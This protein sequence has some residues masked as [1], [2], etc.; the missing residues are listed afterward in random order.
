ME[1]VKN[2]KGRYINKTYLW[3]ET[4]KLPTIHFKNWIATISKDVDNINPS[5]SVNWIKWIHNMVGFTHC[6]TC[7]RLHGC[8]FNALKMPEQPMHER[9]HCS[10]EPIPYSQ[11]LAEAKAESNYSKFDPYLFDPENFYKHKKNVLFEKWGYSIDDSKWLQAEIERQGR[12]KYIAGD[13][14]LGVLNHNGQ[15]ISIR[16]SIPRKDSGE[17]VSFITGWMLC[18]DGKIKLNTP[19]GGK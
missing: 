4:E 9:C 12:E 5:M 10:T 13:Y 16:V 14:T 1:K 6:F 7:I 15:R 11:V 19:Y 2:T 8:W 3:K 17:M 18:P